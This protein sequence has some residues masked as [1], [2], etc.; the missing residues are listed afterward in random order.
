LLTGYV[1]AS[2][3]ALWPAGVTQPELLNCF[4]YTCG[5]S[6]AAARGGA[7]TT[8]LDLSRKYL[9]W[10]ARNFELNSIDVSESRHDFIYGDCA[11]WLR[12]LAKKG[13]LFDC[14]LLDPPTFSTSKVCAAAWLLQR[15]V[16]SSPLP[17][18]GVRF[19]AERDYGALV[20]AALPLI[21]PGGVLFASTN[22][23]RVTPE[24]FV[25]TVKASVAACGRAVTAVH[26]AT[27]AP[28]FTCVEEPAYL[29]TIWLRVS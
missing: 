4:A 20:A 10:G 13:R 29:K 7:R 15:R 26:F 8:S 17:Q 28:D 12:R 11:E 6:V 19:S 18:A 22:A 24:A 21:R 1:S 25:E 9:A 14:V 2:F 23:A 5:L 3:G 16:C 27:Q